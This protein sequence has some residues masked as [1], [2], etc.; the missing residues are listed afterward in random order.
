MKILIREAE[1]VVVCANCGSVLQWRHSDLTFRGNHI[2]CPVC[3]RLILVKCDW[4][5]K[6][7]DL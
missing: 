3:R 1:R 5:Y 2:Q 6:N 7:V 4:N